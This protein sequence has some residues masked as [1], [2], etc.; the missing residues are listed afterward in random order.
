MLWLRTNFLNSV[1]AEPKK[2]STGLIVAGYIFGL[3]SV[4]VLPVPLGITGFVLGIVNLVKGSSGHGI[5]QMIISVACG[6][7]GTCIGVAV[8]QHYVS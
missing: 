6:I 7:I 4:A 8:W 1:D 2:S 5:A 3:L